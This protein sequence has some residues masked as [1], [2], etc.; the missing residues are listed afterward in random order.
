VPAAVIIPVKTLR[1]A[2]TRLSDSL[3]AA[4]RERLMLALL[5][6]VAT[7]AGAADG[8]GAVHVA[9]SDPQAWRTAESFAIS[10]IT[11]GGLEWNRGLVHATSLL[12]PP[13]D[14]VVFVAADLPLVTTREISELVAATPTRGV[15]IGRARDGGTNA[16]AVRPAG[17]LTP[18]FG[19][20]A[21]AAAH[22]A[23]AARAHAQA[24]M[25]DSPGLA[26]DLDTPGD[27]ADALAFDDPD[28]RWWRSVVSAR[29]APA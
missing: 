17:L 15:A 7:R 25:V 28:R 9:T 4:T 3:D 20:P 26:L 19:Q 8:V 5:V 10:V 6:D 14:M 12:V 13:P 23:L 11:D 18:V 22:A 16:L 1:R 21:S 2:K 29:S 24:V 27:L